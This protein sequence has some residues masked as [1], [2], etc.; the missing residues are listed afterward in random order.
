MRPEYQARPAILQADNRATPGLLGEPSQS[1]TANSSSYHQDPHAWSQSSPRYGVETSMDIDPA[2]QMRPQPSTFNPSGI[3]LSQHFQQFGSVPGTINPQLLYP[4]F[5]MSYGALSNYEQAAQGMSMAYD[6]GTWHR[7]ENWAP[8]ALSR[9]TNPYPFRNPI[10]EPYGQ[11]M[12][13]PAQQGRQGANNHQE[14]ARAVITIEWP[15]RAMVDDAM[16]AVFR[17]NGRASVFF[18]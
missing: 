11:A 18:S 4:G 14:T 6:P 1:G 10:I 12:M 13:N 2:A 3:H 7:A 15:S 8:M 17:H 9:I 5:P 16:R